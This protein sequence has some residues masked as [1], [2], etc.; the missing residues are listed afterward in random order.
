MVDQ[1]DYSFNV[2]FAKSRGM[3]KAQ[4]DALET[5]YQKM[6]QIVARPRMHFLNPHDAVEA[7]RGL[8]YAMQILWGFSIDS[9]HH[10]FWYEL[11]GCQCPKMDNAERMGSFCNIITLSCP[12]HGD[13]KANTWEDRRFK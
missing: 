8:E 10:R 9:S 1:K 13:S 11:D 2:T 5:I 12:Y 4:M 7:V 6:A 3:D